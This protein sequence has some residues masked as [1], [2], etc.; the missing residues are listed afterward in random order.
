MN[1]IDN[2]LMTEQKDERGFI[3]KVKDAIIPPKKNLTAFDA[4]TL[5]EYGVRMTEKEI[6]DKDVEKI[7]ASIV[8]KCNSSQTSL[9]YNYDETIPQLEEQ[10]VKHYKDLGYGVVVLNSK[11]DKC[12][13]SSQLYITW[14]R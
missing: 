11:I 12:I 10:L 8:A 9:V 2:S 14:N 13:K 5:T 1:S 6:F 4:Y 7:E 3:T